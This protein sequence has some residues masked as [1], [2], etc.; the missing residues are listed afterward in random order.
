MFEQGLGGG[1]K[2]FMRLYREK[3]FWAERTASAKALGR[4]QARHVTHSHNEVL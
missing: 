2:L 1:G 4:E 3:A